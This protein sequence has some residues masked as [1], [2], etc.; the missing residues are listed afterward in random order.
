MLRI[1]NSR[2]TYLWKTTYGCTWHFVLLW[3]MVY[4]PEAL[5]SEILYLCINILINVQML[6][7]M[8]FPVIFYFMHSIFCVAIL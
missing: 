5:V 4:Y 6:C 2:N 8:L 1:C 3:L 7:K